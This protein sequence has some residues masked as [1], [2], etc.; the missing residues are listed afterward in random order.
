MMRHS[1]GITYL[2]GGAVT[3]AFS[4]WGA[5][6]G[7]LEL[8][9][10]PL[11]PGSAESCA[12]VVAC[13]PEEGVYLVGRAVG[14]DSGT[15]A[16][17]TNTGVT[18]T[19]AWSYGA[20][21]GQAQVTFDCDDGLAG[22]ALFI[23]RDSETGTGE[24]RGMTEDGSPVE[25]WA[26]RAILPFLD[27]TGRRVDGELMCGAAPMPLSRAGGGAVLAALAAGAA[28]QAAVSSRWSA[29]MKRLSQ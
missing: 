4:L 17:E 18:C 23:A 25:A 12:P 13:M 29:W 11:R 5:A 1:R 6:L 2:A 28:P 20:G 7:A 24:A 15:L 26:G 8:P 9:D 10:C 21:G 22:R 19:G 3:T 16:G 14:W 27:A